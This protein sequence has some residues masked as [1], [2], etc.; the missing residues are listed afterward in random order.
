MGLLPIDCRLQLQ[1]I[2]EEE[3]EEVNKRGRKTIKVKGRSA[4][5]R[6]DSGRRTGKQEVKVG[7]NCLAFFWLINKEL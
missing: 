1:M 2:K 6:W 7:N 5:G 3:E 4:R